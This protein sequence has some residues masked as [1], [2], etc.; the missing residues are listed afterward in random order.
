MNT[1]GGVE[2]PYGLGVGVRRSLAN[3]AVFLESCTLKNQHSLF[4]K[5]V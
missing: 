1:E 4:Q 2:T 3:L 5:F